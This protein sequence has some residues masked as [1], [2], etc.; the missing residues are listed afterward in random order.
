MG[1]GGDPDLAYSGVNCWG[2]DMGWDSY[3]GTSWDGLYQANQYNYLRSPV[4]DCSGMK[5]VGLMFKRVLNLRINDFGRIRVNDQ[6][7]WQ[8]PQSGMNTI[9]WKEQ[10][11][12]ISDIADGNSAVTIM[13]ELQSNA[14]N[15]YGGWNIDDVIVAD[16]LMS[17]SSSAETSPAAS[18]GSLTDAWPN[19]FSG[20]TTIRYR[21]SSDGPVEL[22]I[23]DMTGRKVRTLVN[24]LQPSGSHQVDWNGQD[25]RGDEVGSGIYFYTLRVKGT[26]ESR[27]LVLFSGL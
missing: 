9:D 2:T 20:L 23:Y 24:E 27:R 21:L 8:S 16:G 12:D 11:V 22:A 5:D 14:S 7:V 15:H 10:I 26:V 4:I 18:P 19:P 25:D 6:L 17:A 13:F 1:K 3:A